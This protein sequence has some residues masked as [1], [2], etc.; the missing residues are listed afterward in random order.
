MHP[1]QKAPK[2]AYYR[3]L[4]IGD[5]I[6][7]LDSIYAIK[8]LYPNAH[9]CVFCGDIGEQIFAPFSFIDEIV[10]IQN[11]SKKEVLRELDFREFDY[12]ILTQ[13]NRKH[14]SIASNSNAK[15]VISF[16]MWHNIFRRVFGTK[17]FRR[18]FFSR[19]FSHTPNYKRLLSLVRAID[20]AHYDECIS[21]VDFSKARFPFSPAHREFVGQNLA[22]LA[23][24]KLDKKGLK[25]KLGGGILDS[26][27]NVSDNID[28]GFNEYLRKDLDKKINILINPY[29]NSC[30]VSLTKEGYAK[31]ANALATN[32]PNSKI[33]ISSF[34]YAPPLP[35]LENLPNIYTFVN[36][37]DLL[38]LIELVRSAD[39]VIS[40]STSVIHIADNLC[41]KIIGIYSKKDMSLWLGKNMDKSMMIVPKIPTNKLKTHTENAIIESIIQKVL[42]ISQA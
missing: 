18:V 8:S 11:L 16:M 26:K 12:L 39:I 38:N 33:I 21:K 14:T 7:A 37:S 36:N 28:N 4:F 34:A 25:S 9:L 40:P 17:N 42:E 27:Q 13:P 2:I 6:I 3:N 20:T 32:L 41:K 1:L 30:P 29:S 5:S 22:F 10:N 31:L 23:L 35:K 19:S 24:D 15:V